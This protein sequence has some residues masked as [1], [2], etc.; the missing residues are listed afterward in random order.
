MPSASQAKGFSA[1]SQTHVYVC[2]C[3]VNRRNASTPWGSIA[4]FHGLKQTQGINSVIS[5]CAS[6]GRWLEA[7]CL[8]RSQVL[9]AREPVIKRVYMCICQLQLSALFPAPALDAI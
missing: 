1:P 7:G 4:V 2:V 6:V 3:V 9:T 5:V 8:A